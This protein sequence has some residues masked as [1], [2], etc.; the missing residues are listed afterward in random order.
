MNLNIDADDQDQHV[1]DAQEMTASESKPKRFHRSLKNFAYSQREITVP[2]QPDPLFDFHL[3]LILNGNKQRHHLRDWQVMQ[4]RN[5]QQYLIGRTKLGCDFSGPLLGFSYSSLVGMDDENLVYVL[6]GK[7][8]LRDD[9]ED[10]RFFCSMSRI[11][12]DQSI[13]IS[14]QVWRLALAMNGKLVKESKD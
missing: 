5:G 14:P 9:L 11:E 10:W 13:D 7:P 6:M 2:A 3:P 8:R 1:S 4:T 12:S